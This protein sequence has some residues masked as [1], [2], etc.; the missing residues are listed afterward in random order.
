[1]PPHQVADYLGIVGDSSDNIPGVKGIGPKGAVALLE[2]FGSVEGI[3]ERIEEVKKDGQRKTLLE[4]KESALLSKQ[5]A[6]VKRNMDL[7][8]DWHALRCEPRPGG[9][10]F[11]LLD[12]LEFGNLAKR[13]RAW[14]MDGK[15]PQEPAH[16]SAPAHPDR[17][18]D[19]LGP[20]AR[21]GSSEG[22][23]LPACGRPPVVPLH[24]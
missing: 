14:T 10:F 15:A 6:T 7:K 2:Q 12:E 3:Y 8:T 21:L 13:M 17:R 23:R 5:L 4:C 9:A 18:P 20:P 16:A 19:R 22:H 11:A 24:L 1:M